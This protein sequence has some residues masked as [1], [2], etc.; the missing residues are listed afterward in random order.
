[1]SLHQQPL[2]DL[3]RTGLEANGLDI[4][5]P[6]QISDAF[7]LGVRWAQQQS[8]WIPLNFAPEGTGHPLLSEVRGKPEARII[9]HANSSVANCPIY[10]MRES[11]KQHPPLWATHFAIVT[12]LSPAKKEVAAV[13]TAHPSAEPAP[14]PPAFI[15]HYYAITQKTPGTIKHCHGI[16]KEKHALDTGDAYR[17]VIVLIAA[18]HDITDPE[19]LCVCSL[20]LLNPA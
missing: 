5:T 20:T 4:G 6:S 1:M 2:T 18:R 11:W 12:P 16:L 7:R 14:E 3:E 15:Y 10:E 13:Q 9:F 19:T 8:P 17:D